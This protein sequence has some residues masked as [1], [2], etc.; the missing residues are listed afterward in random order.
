MFNIKELYKKSINS[1]KRNN[2]EEAIKDKR[3]VIITKTSEEAL[4]EER[5]NTLKMDMEKTCP[6][7]GAI[8][9]CRI[10]K[11]RDKEGYMYYKCE[12]PY[13]RCEWKG[14]SHGKMYYKKPER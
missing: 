6:E 4:E 12:N 9:N 13:C 1:L 14:R 8:D 5:I 3:D 11:P 10:L 2:K 7:C